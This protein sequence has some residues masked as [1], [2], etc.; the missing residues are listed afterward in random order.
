MAKYKFL[1]FAL[2][3][4]ARNVPKKRCVVKFGTELSYVGKKLQEST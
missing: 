2:K 4:Y 1:I 3:R